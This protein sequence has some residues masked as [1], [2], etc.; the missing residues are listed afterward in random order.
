[1]LLPGDFG[2]DD[3]HKTTAWARERNAVV[4]SRID[5]LVLLKNMRD[6]FKTDCYYWS[7]DEVAGVPE[8][9]WLQLFSGGS[10]DGWRKSLKDRG[11]AVRRVAI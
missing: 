7:S 5:H 6:L 10:Q 11:V 8:C 4:P 2:P 9:A 3:W 1:M